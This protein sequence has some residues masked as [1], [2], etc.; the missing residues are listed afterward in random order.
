MHSLDPVARHA[1]LDP[2]RPALA[3]D[4]AVITYAALDELASRAAGAFHARGVRAG[5]RVAIALPNGLDFVVSYIGARRLGAIATSVSPLWADETIAA[6]IDD[7]DPALL[8]TTPRVGGDVVRGRPMLVAGGSSRGAGS[9]CQALDR[10]SS[11]RRDAACGPPGAPAAILYTSGTTGAPKGVTLSGANIATNAAR[12]AEYCGIGSRDR[13]SLFVPLAHVFGQNAILN[14]TFAGGGCVVLYERFD[15]ERVAADIAAGRLTM[16]FG[17]PAIFPRLLA[18]GVHASTRGALRYA[19]SAAAPLAGEQAMAW[20]DA[21]AVPVHE[22]YGL[23]ESSPFAAYNHRERI[24]P[25]SV[26]AA[27]DDVTIAALDPESGT[28]LSPGLPGELGVRGPNVMLGYW[29]KPSLTAAVLRGGWLRT[30]DV[31][32]LDERGFVFLV[33][34]LDDV[35]NVSGFKVHPEEVERVLRDQPGVAEASAYGVPDPARGARVEAAVVRLPGAI[36]SDAEFAATTLAA[37][38]RRLAPYQLPARIHVRETLPRNPAGKVL[39]RALRESA[40]S[41]PSLTPDL[42]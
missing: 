33:G 15:E 24:V 17:P 31:G 19:F 5:D 20:R 36:A 21:T 30:G 40:I 14:A 26:G 18:S 11:V 12:K 28:P 9:L 3:I 41:R 8:V 13:V 7:A 34:R 23:T 35:V 29:R 16:L 6:A 2:A 10:V 39:R 22:G 37:I 4:D 32:Y 1:V 25:G 42:T 27:I 38:A